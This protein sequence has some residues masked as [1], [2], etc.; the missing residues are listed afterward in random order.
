MLVQR[1]KRN[2][3]KKPFSIRELVLGFISPSSPDSQTYFCL[4]FGETAISMHRPHHSFTEF[5]KWNSC[6]SLSLTPFQPQISSSIKIVVTARTVCRW[7]GLRVSVMHRQIEPP[8]FLFWFCPANREFS[9]CDLI[10]GFRSGFIES[11]FVMLPKNGFATWRACSAWTNKMNAR[12]ILQTG[13]TTIIIIIS[14]AQPNA[15]FRHFSLVFFFHSF[16][17]PVILGWCDALCS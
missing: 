12:H 11:M 13:A 16:V 14:G 6:L 4:L 1:A 7:E 2:R 15:S 17:S 8:A 9:F 10:K 5:A 3:E